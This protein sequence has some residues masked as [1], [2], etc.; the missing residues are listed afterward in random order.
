[1]KKI[2][3]VTGGAKGIGKAIVDELVSNDVVTVVLDARFDEPA[4]IDGIE[5]IAVDVRDRDK[6][7]AVID[8]VVKKYGKIDIAINN[9][10]I[11]RDRTLKNMTSEDWDD[12]IAVNLTGIFN[13][14][15]EIVPQ[16]I[17][18][19]SGAII[20]LSSVIGKTGAIGQAN[21]AAAKA[22]VIGFTKSCALELAR[23]NIC[24]NAVCPGFVDTDMTRGIPADIKEKIVSKIP[25]GR[26]ATPQEIAKV[27]SFIA[28]HNSYITGQSID[29]N[30][31]LFWQ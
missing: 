6:I 3:L 8:G 26:F 28:L 13:V 19:K 23:H 31:G 5:Y 22:G 14:S 16:M 24:V 7:K 30:G 27:V 9:A 4:L 2:A 12:V 17:A 1:M 29:V 15:K 18:Q 21:Y 25:V 20:N 11:V 10:G